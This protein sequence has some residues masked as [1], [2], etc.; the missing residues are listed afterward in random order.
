[1]SSL[2]A[3]QLR[4]MTKVT[5]LLAMDLY[6]KMLAMTLPSKVNANGLK[7][8]LPSQLIQTPTQPSHQSLMS[9]SNAL[10]LTRQIKAICKLVCITLIKWVAISFKTNANGLKLMPPSQLIQTLQLK[11]LDTAS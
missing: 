5:W 9:S 10:P 6:L 1:M 11:N 8:M 4:E 3:S 2:L 7:L